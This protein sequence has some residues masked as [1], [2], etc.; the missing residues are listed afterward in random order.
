MLTLQ[1]I[2]KAVVEEEKKKQ[3]AAV[4]KLT[5]TLK[6]R[7]DVYLNYTGHRRALLQIRSRTYKEFRDHSL[8]SRRGQD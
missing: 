8:S 4:K 6:T 2:A 7:Q 1:Q 5:E 3:K